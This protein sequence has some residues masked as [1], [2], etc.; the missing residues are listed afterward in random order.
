MIGQR[1]VSCPA[2][3][4]GRGGG[5]GGGGGAHLP[6]QRLLP[7]DE[8]CADCLLEPRGLGEQGSSSRSSGKKQTIRQVLGLGRV[9]SGTGARGACSLGFCFCAPFSGLP[10]SPIEA[11][12]VPE[13]SEPSSRLE[14]P[15]AAPAEDAPTMRRRGEAA[16]ELGK[17][18]NPS[19]STPLSRALFAVVERRRATAG[20]RAFR[21]PPPCRPQLEH[22]LVF[23]L[24]ECNSC[25]LTS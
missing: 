7:R 18:T 23:C 25:F 21:N 13:V 10:P 17:E 5:G 9:W 6:Q 3:Q 15:R 1:P 19:E 22:L 14:A 2:L 4:T 8:L 11:P 16:A 20:P 12:P 24:L